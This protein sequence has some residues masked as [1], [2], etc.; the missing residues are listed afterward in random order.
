ME[1]EKLS[2]P[3]K[4]V[5]IDLVLAREKN[6]IVLCKNAVKYGCV[7][8]DESRALGWYIDTISD[9]GHETLEHLYEVYYK[10]FDF[11]ITNRP[12]PVYGPLYADAEFEIHNQVLIALKNY[13]DGKNI[14]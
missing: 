12:A 10:R 3:F 2:S 8:F 5:N 1:I 14:S 13:Y 6:Y 9:N 11:F 4:H 7:Q